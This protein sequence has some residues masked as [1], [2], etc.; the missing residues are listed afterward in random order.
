[1]STQH[2]TATLA[3][4]D[5]KMLGTRITRRNAPRAEPAVADALMSELA[6][7][8]GGHLQRDSATMVATRLV[9]A[10]ARKTAS[11]AS[12]GTVPGGT[13][14]DPMAS[15]TRRAAAAGPTSRPSD[16]TTVCVENRSSRLSG[17]PPLATSVW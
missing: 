13:S 17:D 15:R 3:S 5:S 14:L 4:I 2:N 7:T 10:L 9:I 11:V 1:M 12:T 8:L 16:A 6:C